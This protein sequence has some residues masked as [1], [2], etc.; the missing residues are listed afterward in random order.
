MYLLLSGRGSGSGSEN[1][2]GLFTCSN[3][4]SY[5]FLYWLQSNRCDK[6]I[7]SLNISSGHADSYISQYHSEQGY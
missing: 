3:V 7:L 2:K 1:G 5:L 4:L 6:G